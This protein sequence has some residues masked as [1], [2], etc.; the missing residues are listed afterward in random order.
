M[1]KSAITEM[2][3][4]LSEKPNVLDRIWNNDYYASCDSNSTGMIDHD[5]LNNCLSPTIT[6]TVEI[7]S[8]TENRYGLMN[9]VCAG[10]CGVYGISL[11]Q[12][13]TKFHPGKI[14]TIQHRYNFA[15]FIGLFGLFQFQVGYVWRETTKGFYC[16]QCGAGYEETGKVCKQVWTCCGNV[17][18]STGCKRDISHKEEV[19]ACSLDADE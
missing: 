5:T 17:S 11:S 1:D 13:R 14:R 6:P 4:V 16:Y 7:D 18:G 9:N 12:S 15:P 8:D 19:F 10:T 3:D 2:N